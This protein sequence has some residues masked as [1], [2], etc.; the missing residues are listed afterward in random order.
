[1]KKIYIYTLTTLILWGAAS[2]KK[3]SDFGTVNNDRTADRT[4]IESALLANVQHTLSED[5]SNGA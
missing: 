2:C 1:M 3:P 4:P 5:A